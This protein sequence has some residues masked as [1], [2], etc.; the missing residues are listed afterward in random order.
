MAKTK[1]EDAGEGKKI[2]VQNRKARHDYDIVDR[3]ET[4]IVLQGTEVKSLRAGKV[5]LKDSYALVE[6]REVF[7]HRVHIGAYEGGTHY[8]HEPERTRKLLLHAVEIRRLVAGHSSKALLFPLSVYFL[9]GRAKI[10][11]GVAKGKKQY[12]KRNALAERQAQRGSPTCTQGSQSV[13]NLRWQHV[14]TTDCLTCGGIGVFYDSK[15]QVGRYGNLSL[16]S[17]IREECLCNGEAPFQYWDEGGR[18]TGALVVPSAEGL[19]RPIACIRLLKFQSGIAGS[20][21]MIL[22]RLR[23]IVLRCLMWMKYLGLLLRLLVRS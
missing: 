23:P 13:S 10:E 5:N 20:F 22:S 7:L 16:C 8:N 2:I 21:S 15:I 1:K 19:S 4:G 11:L 18:G 14:R 17:C 9:K 6:G 12:D 3:I